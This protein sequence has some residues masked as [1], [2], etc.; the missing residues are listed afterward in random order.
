[1]ALRAQKRKEAAEPATESTEEEG[2]D[3]EDGDEDDDEEEDDETASLAPLPESGSLGFD[4]GAK[5]KLIRTHRSDSEPVAPIE[6][7]VAAATWEFVDGPGGLR[8]LQASQDGF[9][10]IAC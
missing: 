9:S 7:L 4:G 3:D 1:L 5:L 10:S 6:R 8:I 2:D